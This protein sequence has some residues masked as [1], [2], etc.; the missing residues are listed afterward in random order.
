MTQNHRSCTGEHHRTLDVEVGAWPCGKVRGHW[1]RGT[2]IVGKRCRRHP[3]VADRYKLWNAIS[4]CSRQQI[5][6]LLV[7]L[8]GRPFSMTLPW[9]LPRTALPLAARSLWVG[10][11]TDVV[12]SYLFS[13]P[14]QTVHA[15]RL[16]VGPLTRGTDRPDKPTA[17]V[18]DERP[19]ARRPDVRGLFLSVTNHTPSAP[20][21]RTRYPTADR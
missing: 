9:Q 16:G 15:T 20:P 17:F 3:P 2:P 5:E 13:M 21:A 7:S 4:P 19:I 6:R 11:S 14:R 18:C 12:I 10:C 1:Q 8:V